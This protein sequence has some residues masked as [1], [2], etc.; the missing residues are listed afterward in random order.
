NRAPNALISP[1]R[2]ERSKSD[3]KRIAFEDNGK[4]EHDV[5]PR[6]IRGRLRMENIQQA[7]ISRHAAADGENHDRHDQSPKIEFLAV[8]EGV[9]GVGWLLFMPNR[10]N[11]PFP[12]STS[13]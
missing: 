11:P 12:V 5:I 13:E 8:S 1:C 2:L 6:R 7:F 4:T 10:S 9:G 3:R